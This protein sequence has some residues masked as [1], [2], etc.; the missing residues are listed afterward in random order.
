MKNPVLRGPECVT[1]T[2]KKDG[3]VAVIHTTRRKITGRFILSPVVGD[4]RYHDGGRHKAG[5][6]GG[7]T[8]CGTRAVA[9][10]L[11]IPYRE[12]YN[13]V[14]RANKL[15]TGHS[16]R[17]GTTL[18]ALECVLGVKAEEATEVPHNGIVVTHNH[19]FAVVDGIRHDNHRCRLP[20][21][22]KVLKAQ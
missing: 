18:P 16:A 7:T 6:K 4:F 9:L 21:Q 5:F 22:F 15:F 3:W 20:R 12:A 14:T 13:K 19:A 8:D 2:H 10:H 1:E 17:Q 11:G